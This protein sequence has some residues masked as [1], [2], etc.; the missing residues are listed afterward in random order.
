MLQRMELTSPA[1]Q[2]VAP[3]TLL[4]INSILF[5]KEFTLLALLLEV[6]PVQTSNSSQ[7][8]AMRKVLSVDKLIKLALAC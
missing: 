5:R 6:Q 8:L 7:H 1:S 2:E 3:E 4:S